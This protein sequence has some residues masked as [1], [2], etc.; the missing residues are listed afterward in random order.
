[1]AQRSKSVKKILRLKLSRE[2][3]LKRKLDSFYSSLARKYANAFKEQLTDGVLSV[4]NNAEKELTSIILDET[5]KTA[6][7]LGATQANALIKSAKPELRLKVSFNQV[8]DDLKVFLLNRATRSV[9]LISKTERNAVSDIIARGIKEGLGIPE[10]ADNLLKST[11]GIR[12]KSIA[13]TIART[14]TGIVGSYS[15]NRGAEIAQ[16]QGIQFNKQWIAVDDVRTRNSHAEVDNQIVGMSELFN[17]SGDLMSHP[18]D[19]SASAGNV[20]NCRCVVN[21]IPL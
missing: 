18:H 4:I 10:I 2:L 13:S 20:I 8:E 15:Q 12:G 5:T 19:T 1:M 9:Y 17:V 7:V 21:Y 6:G 14:E 11:R 3:A 16:N